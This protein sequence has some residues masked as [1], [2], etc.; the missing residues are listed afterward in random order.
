MPRFSRDGTFA[1]YIGACTDVSERK[2]AEEA[3]SSMS[4]RLIEAQDLERAGVAMH[5]DIS[6]RLALVAMDLD[7]QNH[8][9]HVSAEELRLAIGETYK[10]V[11][12]LVSDI[13]VL[14]HKLHSAKLDSMGL[15]AAAAGFCRELSERHKLL[16]DFSSK[17]I[18]NKVPETISLCLF[19]VL[20]EA[21]QN[22]L[23]HSGAKQIRVS[24]LGFMNEIQLTICDEGRGFD[25]EQVLKGTGLG[26]TSMKERLKLVGGELSIDTQL[27]HG[28]TIRARVPLSYRSN[29]SSATG[30]H[31]FDPL[32]RK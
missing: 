18:P 25:A 17:G 1:G 29:S 24:V 26:L 32:S 20:Q 22:A 14:S 13:H 6:Q 19:R 31:S 28:T 4:R 11:S 3:L 21:L 2:I 15:I 30:H 8:N 16:I 12:E 27:Q 9:L 5:D 7:R 10:Q 23:K